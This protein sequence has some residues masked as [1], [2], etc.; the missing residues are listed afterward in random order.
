[1]LAPSKHT[2]IEGYVKEEAQVRWMAI[3]TAG[4]RIW[5]NKLQRFWGEVYD[6]NP[7]TLLDELNGEKRPQQLLNLPREWP[8]ARRVATVALGWDQL[9]RPAADRRIEAALHACA[10]TLAT[11]APLWIAGPKP[12]LAQG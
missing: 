2:V 3:A 10:C 5:D 4:W 12:V 11:V 8:V 1:M 7:Q 9:A 6:P